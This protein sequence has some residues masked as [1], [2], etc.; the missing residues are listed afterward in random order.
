MKKNLRVL[1][2]ALFVFG[3][4][5]LIEFITAVFNSGPVEVCRLNYRINYFSFFVEKYRAL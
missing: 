3:I 1:M 2:I 4:E 5:K